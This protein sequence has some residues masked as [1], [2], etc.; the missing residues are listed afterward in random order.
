MSPEAEGE[1]VAAPEGR[2]GRAGAVGNGASARACPN[3]GID[4]HFVAGRPHLGESAWILVNQSVAYVLV[5]LGIWLTISPWRLR[6]WINWNTADDHRMKVGAAVRLA[7]GL[8]FAAL[9]MFI[10]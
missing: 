5:V 2:G 9:G 6:D 8:S 3:D 4:V 7:C 1:G 10:F